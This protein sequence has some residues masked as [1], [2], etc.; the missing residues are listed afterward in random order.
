MLK[1]KHQIENYEEKAKI[2]QKNGWE[3][4]YHVD[5]WIRTEWIK[6]EK[7]YDKMGISTD[8]AYNKILQ[9]Q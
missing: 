7:P 5:N 4:W 3:I 1:E 6:Q 2:L 8:D 9:K